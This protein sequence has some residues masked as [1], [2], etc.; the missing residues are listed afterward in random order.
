MSQISQNTPTTTKLVET[1]I[2]EQVKEASFKKLLEEI[3]NGELM[4]TGNTDAN[5]NDDDDTNAD[6]DDAHIDEDGMDTEDTNGEDDD[7]DDDE[8]TADVI[9]E[10]SD[11]LPGRAMHSFK[12]DFPDQNANEYEVTKWI[13]I[14]ISFKKPDPSNINETSQVHPYMVKLASMI[15]NA[16]K[17]NNKPVEFMSSKS[18][19][20]LM[21]T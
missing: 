19:T 2:T 9:E 12:N 17:P 3:K 21:S 4:E 5:T 20:E 1:E 18:R 15:N 7:D 8:T 14:R 11:P 10:F 16:I 6:A 13:P